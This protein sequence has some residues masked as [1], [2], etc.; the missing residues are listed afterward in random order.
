MPGDNGTSDDRQLPPNPLRAWFVSEIEMRHPLNQTEQDCEIQGQHKQRQW[1][2]VI[3]TRRPIM[4][5]SSI[6]QPSYPVA[7]T[8]RYPAMRSTQCPM[9][10]ALRRIRTG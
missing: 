5:N 3:P 2:R 9:M 8:K 4:K 6:F 10:I 7:K 1:A